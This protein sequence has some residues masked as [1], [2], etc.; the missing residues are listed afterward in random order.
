MHKCPPKMSS[1]VVICIFLRRPLHNTPKPPRHGWVGVV[2]PRTGSF[3][4]AR[5]RLPFLTRPLSHKCSS[6]ELYHPEWEPPLASQ[7]SR[8]G[9]E[10][11]GGAPIPRCAVSS[12]ADC[13]RVSPEKEAPGCRRQEPRGRKMK[14]ESGMGTKAGGGMRSGGEG[15]GRG[16][17]GSAVPYCALP[18]GSSCFLSKGKKSTVVWASFFASFCSGSL[19]PTRQ[20]LDCTL[21]PPPLSGG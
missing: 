5:A 6:H 17:G 16:G 15:G 8:A 3:N 14:D 12:F 21:E 1:S 18:V 13:R 4:D 2:P 10:W 20:I 7:M 9:C 11:G 19:S